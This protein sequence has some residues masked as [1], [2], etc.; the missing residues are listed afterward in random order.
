MKRVGRITAAIGICLGI[1]MPMCGCDGDSSDPALTVD[2][3][4]V[5][6]G[7]L[8]GIY[9]AFESMQNGDVVE[10]TE[11]SDGVPITIT[12]KT[13]GTLVATTSDVLPDATIASDGSFT[14]SCIWTYGERLLVSGPYS[15]GKFALKVGDLV[16]TEVSQETNYSLTFDSDTC[17]GT[18]WMVALISTTGVFVEMTANYEISAIRQD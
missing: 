16:P 4:R 14:T 18:I 12:V 6:A 9:A 11:S 8:H 10:C 7:T 3:T 2:T 13:D 17:S 1:I 5:Y 15:N